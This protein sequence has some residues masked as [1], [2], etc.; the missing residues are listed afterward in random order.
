MRATVIACQVMERELNFLAAKSEHII[1][2]RY[3]KQGL[4]NTPDLLRDT[5]RAEIAKAEE[6]ADEWECPGPEVILLGYGLCSN[7]V[8]GLTAGRL[9]LVVPR[10]DDCIAIFLGSQRRYLDCFATMNGVYWYNPGWIETAHTPSEANYRRELERYT[11]LYGEDNAQFLMEQTN[12]WHT[13]YSGCAYITSQIVDN[14]PYEAY[15]KEAAK[16]LG[17][18]YTKVE[19]SLRM[20]EA[21]VS[22]NW[23]EKE[24]LVCPPGH[25]IRES[26][27]E[28]KIRAVLE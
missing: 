22:G 3:Q 14:A 11:Q 19:G 13:K 5:L 1:H 26:Y 24:F 4:H 12:G 2:V 23:N 18:N 17:W 6:A 20:L 28:K 10:T 7:G 25:T 21:L 27:N 9:P 8:V 15:T 16:F